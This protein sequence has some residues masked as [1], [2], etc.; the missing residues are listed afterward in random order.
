MTGPQVC[1]EQ[2]RV[3]FITRVTTGAEGTCSRVGRV[4]ILLVIEWVEVAAEVLLMR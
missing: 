3:R 2:E 1:L 4:N